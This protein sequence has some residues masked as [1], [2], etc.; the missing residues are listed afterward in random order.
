ME[1]LDVLGPLTE[2]FDVVA[3]SPG[4]HVSGETSEQGW[5]RAASRVPSRS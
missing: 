2:D 4:V 3:P 1:F 5:H